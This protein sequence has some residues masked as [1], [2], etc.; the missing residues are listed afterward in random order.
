MDIRQK[1]NAITYI[2]RRS[3]APVSDA[4]IEELA[5]LAHEATY[6]K[7]ATILDIGEKQN[8]VY[9]ILQGMA[10]SY[11]ID[12]KGNDITKLFMRENE[13][14]I[15][16]ALF[17]EESLEVFEAVEALKCL[18]FEVKAFKAILLSDPE[19]ER[20]YIAILEQTIRYKMR[21]EYAFQCMDATERY[22]EFQRVYPGIEE[23]LQQN[24][25][26]SY[27]GITKESLSRI[28]KKL[29]AN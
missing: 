4:K 20:S 24:L 15:G 28:R 17:M 7:Q 19:L 27:L 12:E 13:F 2:F 3:G 6:P 1:I 5:T 8:Y 18:R 25:I 9:L 23:R 29:A 22:L 14:L 16:E 10:R 26:A 21:R 11:Y